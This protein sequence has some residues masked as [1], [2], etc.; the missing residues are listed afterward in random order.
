MTNRQAKG[1]TL[2][3]LLI[4]IAIIGLLASV[5]VV[6]LGNSRIK[7]RDARRLADTQQIR[8]ALDLYLNQAGG[9]PDESVWNVG[10][11]ISCAGVTLMTVPSD[12][13]VGYSYTYKH[14]G[15]QGTSTVCGTVWSG[16]SLEFQ[17][18]GDTVIGPP[19]H[20]CLRPVEGVTPGA[21]P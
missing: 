17:T 11:L 1:F 2:I 10:G 14:T 12:P 3:E 19:Q 21:C 4:V 20:Y 5:I 7:A 16:Y 15:T 13:G 18:E 8:T 9:Y 6:A